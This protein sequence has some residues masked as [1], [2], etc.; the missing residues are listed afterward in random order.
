MLF[1]ET[2]WRGCPRA[3]LAQRSFLLTVKFTGIFE[4]LKQMKE[5]IIVAGD[6]KLN[7]G[8]LRRCLRKQG[9]SSIPCKT[10][11]SIIEEL[12]IL[13]T[14]DACVSLV[15][16]EPEMLRDINDCLVVQLSECALDVP[17]IFSDLIDVSD[18]LMETF[19]QICT[20]RAKFIPQQNPLA[21]VLKEAGVK[22]TCN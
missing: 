13:P 17:F 11:E 8:S 12:N 18:D 14:A 20:C 16:I 19:E 6:N 5:I 4:G 2:H 22:V 10:V 21:D 3:H 1:C 7:V 15:V 9:Y